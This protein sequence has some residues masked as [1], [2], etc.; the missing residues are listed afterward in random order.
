MSGSHSLVPY[1]LLQIFTEERL[2][3]VWRLTLGLGAVF[4]ISILYFRL[5]MQEPKR[6]KESSMSQIKFTKLP[7]GLIFSTSGTGFDR[8]RMSEPLSSQENMARAF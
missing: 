8:C 2:E 5:Q 1:I 7:W 3:W 4:P 6:Y